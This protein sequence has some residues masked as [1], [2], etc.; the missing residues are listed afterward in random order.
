MDKLRKKSPKHIQQWVDSL[1]VPEEHLQKTA[2][3]QN[4]LNTLNVAGPVKSTVPTTSRMEDVRG[5]LSRDASFQSD[6]ASS[7]CSSVES[8]LELRR[9]DPEAVLIGLGFGP[10]EEDDDA[11]R[12]PKRF[13]QPSKV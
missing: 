9:P 5:I 11:H 13:L 1:P 6:D 7:H 3:E 8:V 2:V 12:I 10:S 4:H